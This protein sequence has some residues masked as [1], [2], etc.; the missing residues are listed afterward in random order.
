MGETV[1]Q[2][3]LRDTIAVRRN[4]R[5]VLQ[6]AVRIDGAVDDLLRRPAIANNARAVATVVHVAP[7]A[8]AR[9]DGVRAALEGMDAGASAW[10][11]LL[12]ARILAP[13]GAGVRRAV[14][15]V[16][17]ALRD[18]PLPRVWLC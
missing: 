9:L 8:E 4:G 10:N 12:L 14:V 7:D 18:R 5:T 2:A 13:D 3:I 1:R 6:D 11:G 17:A 16:L 15:S